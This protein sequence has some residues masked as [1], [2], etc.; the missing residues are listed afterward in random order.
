MPIMSIPEMTVLVYWGTFFHGIYVKH[1]VALAIF[2]L[3]LQVKYEECVFWLSRSLRCLYWA[4]MAW[5]DR[6]LCWLI[7]VP[8]YKWIL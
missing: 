7:I 6:V 8:S 1:S 3:L 2:F 4:H 5:E